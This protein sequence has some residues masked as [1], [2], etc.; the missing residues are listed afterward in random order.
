MGF[1]PKQLFF[2][3]GM[4]LTGTINTVSRKIQLEC[5]ARGYFNHSANDTRTEHAFNKPWFQ[6]LLMF[7][8][9]IL[10]IFV[11][12]ILR[13]KRRVKLRNGFV[14]QALNSSVPGSLG[15]FDAPLFNWFFFIPASCDLLG[16]S[17]AGIGLLFVDASIWQM[18]RGSLIV[19]AGL[20][21]IGFLRRRLSPH[22]WFGM[23]CTV[24]GL[25]LVGTKSVFS[26]H[27]INHTAAQSAL[28][29]T[30]VLAGTFTSACQMIIEEVFL[31]KRS[32][33]PLQ[34]VGMEGL[35]GTLM[36][37]TIA[38]PAVHFI[39]G[40]DLNG[41]YENIIDAL[42]QIGDNV[43]LMVNVILYVLSIA[44]F[45]YFGLSITRNLSAV[46]RTLIDSLR[47]TFVWLV[48]MVIYY[49][50]HGRYGEPF[51]LS[52]G[53]IQIDGF[54]FLV[55]GTLIYNKVMDLTFIPCCS[56]RVD[57]PLVVTTVDVEPV[58]STEEFIHPPPTDEQTPI[59]SSS[60]KHYGVNNRS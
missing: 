28:G 50:T 54:T 19:F 7:L 38:L 36:M 5:T 10:C 59:S 27:S 40:N 25:A 8:G 32:C 1:T 14:Y 22:H 44:F 26:T 51:D 15:S 47:T 2:I 60:Q 49:S 23:F 48:S 29:V 33:H 45:N 53:L 21:S 30:L 20:L 57:E 56:D 58:Y 17:L 42:Y 24:I 39:P 55:I 6:T 11:F 37:I 52:W 46:H 9:E 3:F 41:S 34:V 31:K 4:L 13:H 43:L 12:F 16:S 18:M 35:F